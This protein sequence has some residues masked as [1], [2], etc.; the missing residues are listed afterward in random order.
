[1]SKSRLVPEEFLND[2]V[3]L[4]QAIQGLELDGGHPVSVFSEK[5]LLCLEKKLAAIDRREKW[6]KWGENLE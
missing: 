5:M 3:N 1:M 6:K 4:Y 2:F